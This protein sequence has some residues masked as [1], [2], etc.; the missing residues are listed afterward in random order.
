VKVADMMTRNPAYCSPD[1]NLAAAVEILWNRN[2]GIL[3][4]VDSSEKLIGLVTDRDICVAVGTRNRL[5]SEISVNEVTSGNVITCKADDDVRTALATMAK[6]KVRRLPVVD[7]ARKLQGIL[8][9]DDVVLHTDP[10]GARKDSEAT[11]E[12]V[13]NTLRTVYRP[14]PRQAEKTKLAA[15]N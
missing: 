2:C 13:V 1:T 4:I 11:A 12:E 14:Q 9:L 7:S 3:P 6:A 8:S 10:R 5:P 15:A